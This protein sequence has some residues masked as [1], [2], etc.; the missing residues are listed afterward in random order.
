M[1]FGGSACGSPHLIL[2]A[3]L[4]DP[5]QLVGSDQLFQV[6]DALPQDLPLVGLF[7]QDPVVFGLKDVLL[8]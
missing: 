1:P 3:G 4:L 7:D 6:M 8:E 2:A 5:A